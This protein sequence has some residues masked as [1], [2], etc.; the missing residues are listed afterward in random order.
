M[1]KN[2]NRALKS[3]INCF[4]VKGHDFCCCGDRNHVKRVTNR[5]R[6]A[7]DKALVREEA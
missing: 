5:A 2:V 1:N 6:R 3:V 7:V 4:S